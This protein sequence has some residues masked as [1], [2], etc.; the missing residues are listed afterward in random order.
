MALAAVACGPTAPHETATVP[1]WTLTDGGWWASVTSLSTNTPRPVGA[2][3]KG[4]QGPQPPPPPEGFSISSDLLFDFGSSRLSGPAK[5]VITDITTQLVARGASVSISGFCDIIGS[6]D[7]NLA[8]SRKRAEVVAVAMVDAGFPRA[9]IVSIEGYGS[10]RP[11]AT[12][13]DTPSNRALNRR[14]ELEILH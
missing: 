10:A 11:R 7:V 2:G 8:L 1:A 6:E 3:E 13:A 5:E 14:V 4:P 9:Q 12:P